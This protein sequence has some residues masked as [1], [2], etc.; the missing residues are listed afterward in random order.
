MARYNKIF[1]GPVEET[2]PQVRELNASVALKP[3]RLVVISSGEWALA[4]ATTVGKVW[5]VQDNYLAM[6]G[7]DDD[8]TQDT[9]AIGIEMQD[10]QLYAARIANGVNITA[11]GTALTPGANG[12]LAIASTE[13]LIVA[14]S[15][16]VYNNN[17]GSEQLLK[18]RPAGSQSYLSA[19]A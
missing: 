5:L 14:Y 1:L 12:T 13:D 17:S 7:V 4:A 9:T 2:K 18:V 10:D 19:A 16:E 3:G 8:W 6:K 15:E 11:I